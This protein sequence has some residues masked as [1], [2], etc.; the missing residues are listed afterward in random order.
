SRSRSVSP[1][2]TGRRFAGP[3]IEAMRR[4][5]PKSRRRIAMRKGKLGLAKLL[6]IV[7]TATAASGCATRV[8]VDRPCGV[9]VDDLRDVRGKTRADDLRISKHFEAGVAAGCWGR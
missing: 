1:P 2:I 8:A 5:S 4:P 9:I 7:A 6:L 3:M